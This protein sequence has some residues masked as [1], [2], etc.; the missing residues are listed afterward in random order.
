MMSSTSSASGAIR[1][2]R[3]EERFGLAIGNGP[4]AARDHA[5]QRFSCVVAHVVQAR[6]M[7]DGAPNRRAPDGG[8]LTSLRATHNR[9]VHPLDSTDFAGSVA[10]T[11]A[12]AA[13]MTEPGHV[14]VE[15]SQVPFGWSVR[16]CWVNNMWRDVWF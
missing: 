7:S 5:W 6:F 9:T 12:F 10:R 1:A 2:S 13:A 3:P 16:L 4:T 15:R 11:G 14:D 8:R